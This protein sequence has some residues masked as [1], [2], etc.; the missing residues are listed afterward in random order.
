MTSNSIIFFSNYY[1]TRLAYVAE[2]V[3]QDLLG[4][5]IVFTQNTE[6]YLKSPLPKINYSQTPLSNS[7]IFIQNQSVLF[8]TDI[9]K[10]AIDIDFKQL[11]QQS[12]LDFDVLA[13]IFILI[14]RY[15]EY[16]VDP[17]LLDVHQRF[18]AKISLASRFGFLQKPVI[19]QWVME[20]NRHL[21]MKFPELQTRLS[22]YFFQPTFDIDMPWKYKNKGF[23]RTIGGFIKDFVKGEFDEIKSRVGVLRGSKLDP[24]FTFE[25]IFDIHKKETI[26]PLFFL[27][28]GNLTEFDKNPNVH[29][30]PFQKFIRLVADQY[31]VGLHPS[32]RSN[33]S[34]SILKTEKKRFEQ[35]TG[36]PLLKSR[37]HFLKLSFP[38]TYQNL[39]ALGVKH[40][41]SMG[42][43]DNIGFRASIA[44]PFRWFDLTKNEVTDLWI[45]SFQVMEVTLKDYL[46][47]TPE[48]ALKQ[49]AILIEETKA[50]GGTFMTLWHNSSLIHTEGW[51]NWQGVYEKILALAIEKK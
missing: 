11:L 9:I 20:I 8:E 50:V 15:E 7:E 45:H 23:L 41:Y 42:Y 28:L 18:P 31:E 46:C 6:G 36:Q 32:Y 39:L 51:Q 25:N 4:L 37:Q 16:V 29:N 48:K 40:E 22:A 47:H 49:V 5:T 12:P 21:K 35:L 24:Y 3:F 44:T 14:T 33:S 43:A 26:R 1:T 38:E 34:L 17:L 10:Q 13:V 19:N 2:L 30:K 27:L